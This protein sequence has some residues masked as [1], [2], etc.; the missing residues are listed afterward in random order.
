VA[1]S[2]GETGRSMTIVGIIQA[3]TGSTR[4]PGKVL[5]PLGGRTVLERM[6]ERVRAAR[7]LDELVVAT[8]WLPEDQPIRALAAELGVPCVSSHPTDLLARHIDVAAATS[9]GAVVKIPS[10]CPLIDPRVIDEVVGTFRR[11]GPRFDYVSNL[12]PASWPDGNDVEVVRR[13]ALEAAGREARLP[14]E[15][16]HTTPFLWDQPERF[17]LANVRWESGLDY[18]ESHRFTVDYPDDYAFVGAVYD[19]LYT[20]A[21]P[22]FSLADI[23]ALLERR[24]ELLAL[25]ARYHGHTWQKRQHGELRHAPRRFRETGDYR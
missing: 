20:D 8:T 6:I 12:H 1:I 15:R 16:E 19:A 9:A 21:R 4:L 10:D 17:R 14:R 13:S 24:P 3:R 23:L 5:L 7:Q 11:H 18:S 2:D 25:N 22:A